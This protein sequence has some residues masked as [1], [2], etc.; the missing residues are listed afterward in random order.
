VELIQL[1]SELGRGVRQESH[2]DLREGD[3]R[4]ERE[5]DNGRK[6][7]EASSGD[8]DRIPREQATEQEHGRELKDSW[9]GQPKSL[10]GSEDCLWGRRNP[11]D[12]SRPWQRRRSAVDLVRVASTTPGSSRG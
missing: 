4:R 11:T 7:P 2:V 8:S 3:G 5:K 9:R 1:L 12:R 10:L 6:V